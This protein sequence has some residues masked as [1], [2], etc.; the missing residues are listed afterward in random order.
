MWFLL[1]SVGAVLVGAAGLPAARRLPAAPPPEAVLACYFLLATLLRLLVR[2]ARLA[3]FER[4]ARREARRKEDTSKPTSTLGELGLGVGR[5]AVQ[6]VAGDV[7]GAGLSLAT[8]LLR[9]AA[10]SL[11]RPPPPQ[12]E[13]RRAA[14]WEELKTATSIAGVGL[15][16]VAVAWE[17]LV[18][19]RLTRAADAA[20]RAGIGEPN[21]AGAG[22]DP[23]RVGAPTRIAPRRPAG[24]GPAATQAALVGP[25]VGPTPP[26]PPASPDAVGPATGNTA[27]PAPADAVGPPPRDAQE[28][29]RPGGPPPAAPTPTGS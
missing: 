3:S 9:G 16:C 20:V 13:R 18:H 5:G 24:P 22:R 26:P 29:D 14:R 10:S 6:V 23:T 7:L 1:F 27:G 25:S 19:A 12:R 21:V 4:K 28:G 11:S 15:V 8:A 17:P 2:N